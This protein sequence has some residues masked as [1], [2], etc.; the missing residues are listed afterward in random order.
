MMMSQSHEGAAA[1]LRGLASWP[2]R[3]QMLYIEDVAFDKFG[4]FDD[5]EP[6]DSNTKCLKIP[7]DS[8]PKCLKIPGTTR[9]SGNFE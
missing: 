7:R 3:D 9:K 2:G 6:R 4:N 5:P 1:G 8:I